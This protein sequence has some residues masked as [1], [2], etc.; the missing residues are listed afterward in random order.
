MYKRQAYYGA[1]DLKDLIISREN[2]N[3]EDIIA[4]SY[5]YLYARE[6]IEDCLE[7]IKDYSEDSIPV[8]SSDNKLLGVVTSQS[9]VQVVDEELGDDYAKL[10]GLTAEE[11]LNEPT[12]QSIRKRLPWLLILMVLGM[13]VSGVVGLFEGIMAQLTIIVSFQSLI[14][15]MAG[16][17][18]TQSL[19][20]TILSLIH[21]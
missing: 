2:S 10:G 9:I 12:I 20:V 8:L 17:V 5:P 16:N 21:I 15:D 1:I 13:V 18:G 11:D 6:Q 7:R 3:L 14:L 4:T 19:A